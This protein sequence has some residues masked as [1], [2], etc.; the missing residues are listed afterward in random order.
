MNIYLAVYFGAVILAII[1][2]P[3]VMILARK[4][5]IADEPNARKVHQKAIPH[6]GGVSF[7]IAMQIATLIVLVFTDRFKS[8][9]EESRTQ[10]LV[11]L[12]SS[13][14]VGIMGLYDDVRNLSG[15]TKLLI[16]ILASLMAYRYGIAIDTITIH[17]VISLD[18]GLL[19]LPV[20]I[21]WITAVT[22]GLNFLDGLDGLA[23][24]LSAIACVIIGIFALLTGQ[25]LLAIMMFALLGGLTSFLSYNFNPAR[26][27]MGD[28]GSMFLGFI[29][30]SASIMCITGTHSIKGL[31]ISAIAFGIPVIDAVCTVI[32][33]G[34][35]ER[36]SI[37][38]AERGHVHHRLLDAGL[39]HRN[40]V[41]ALYLVAGLTAGMGL[42][43]LATEGYQTLMLFACVVMIQLMFFRIVGSIKIGHT[44]AA[45]KRNL[46]I[47]KENKTFK[48]VFED[49]QLMM[50][51]G[52]NFDEWWA[53]ICF[54][55]EK[56]GL[57]FIAVDFE[58]RDGTQRTSVWRN[59]K[60][61]PEEFD[62]VHL[63]QLTIP[64]RQRRNG[65]DLKMEAAAPENGSLELA[66]QRLS[67][68]TRLVE[69]HPLS[70]LPAETT[71]EH[72]FEMIQKKNQDTETS[73]TSVADEFV[74]VTS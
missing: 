45:A 72:R 31:T 64:L 65:R 38:K 46:A 41:I 3:F 47:R 48:D 2:T 13:L 54:V 28:C 66:A 26:V 7:I 32:R 68:L 61:A 8:G 52:C 34:V 62:K 24:G 4:W 18:I 10:I 25:L 60:Y 29:L 51:K 16:L 53:T 70:K 15:R 55:A 57:A 22:V 73:L 59:D 58:N 23:A 56:M 21:V 37:F 63:A 1:T 35:L 17:G 14:L 50:R 43:M 39:S 71:N 30:G 12:A 67:F 9:F 6:I 42:F 44:M 19:S 36:R 5:H 69:E 49:G 33:R 27:F 11:L 74:K 20:T 40:V